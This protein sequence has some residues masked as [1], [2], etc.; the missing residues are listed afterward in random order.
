[1]GGEKEVKKKFCDFCGKEFD[2]VGFFVGQTSRYFA[3]YSLMQHEDEFD[4]CVNCFKE[5][6]SGKK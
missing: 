4:C 5:L 2:E 6:V 1:L 3:E